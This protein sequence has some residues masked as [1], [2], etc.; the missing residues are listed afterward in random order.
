MYPVESPNQAVVARHVFPQEAGDEFFRWRD[1]EPDQFGQPAGLP[2]VVVGADEV[3]V[4]R[5]H[6]VH[7]FLQEGDVFLVGRGH[8]AHGALLYKG[9]VWRFFFM[10]ELA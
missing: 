10:S 4:A 5:V 9:M 8:F 7:P 1:V 2:S 3:H 6:P